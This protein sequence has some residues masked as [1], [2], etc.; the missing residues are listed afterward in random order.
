MNR[1]QLNRS[2]ESGHALIEMAISLTVMVTLISGIFQMGY[3]FYTYNE[4]VTAVGN[5]ARYA[6]AAAEGDSDKVRNVVAFGNPE[7]AADAAPVVSNLTPQF[8]D[9]RWIKSGD[10]AISSV[11]VSIREFTVGSFF[12]VFKFTNRPGVEFPYIGESRA[13]RDGDKPSAR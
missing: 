6:S 3:V 11:N 9:V 2:R 12:R 10:G 7:P 1:D 8:V 4:L 13:S 5:G